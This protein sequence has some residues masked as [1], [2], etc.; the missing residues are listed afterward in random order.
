MLVDSLVHEDGRELVWLVSEH[1]CEVKAEP[2]L[3]GA[4][5]ALLTLD[6]E[7][8]DGPV[9]IPAYGVTVLELRTTDTPHQQE[10]L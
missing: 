7:P 8:V 1:D 3:A 9:S 5:R 2:R 4:G 6:G 10:E